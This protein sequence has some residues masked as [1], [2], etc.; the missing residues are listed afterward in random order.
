MQ[1][2]Q[3]ANAPA[4]G[5]TENGCDEVGTLFV[6]QMS[7][8]TEVPCDQ[9]R[10]AARS[11]LHFDIMVE[12][13]AEHVDVG[14]AFGRAVVPAAGVGDIANGDGPAPAL[15]LRLDAETVRWTTIMIQLDGLD[16]HAAGAEEW[17]AIIG[18]N[19]A[20]GIELA[21]AA[22]ADQV[23]AVSVMAIK[24][25]RPAG[26]PAQGQVADMIAVCVRKDHSPDVLPPCA[27]RRHALGR[28]ARAQSQVDHQSNAPGTDQSAISLRP[29]RKHREMNGHG[30]RCPP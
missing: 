28:C 10:R 22:K 25:N 19:E 26:E 7:A 21:K 24:R 23:G 2:H 29:A 20:K 5:S 15:R 3:I 8:I 9:V 27:D 16:P 1:Q 12:L 18:T 6:G 13:D 4:L 14:Q 30:R 17:A 11:A